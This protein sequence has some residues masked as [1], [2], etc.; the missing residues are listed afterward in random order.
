MVY[1]WPFTFLMQSCSRNLINVLH[2]MKWLPGGLSEIAVFCSLHNLALVFLNLSTDCLLPFWNRRL[3]RWS[4]RLRNEL[5]WSQKFSSSFFLS[6]SREIW[7]KHGPFAVG[8]SLIFKL[9]NIF[10]YVKLVENRLVSRSNLQSYVKLHSRGIYIYSGDSGDRKP[11][12]WYSSE[13]FA[14]FYLGLV[15]LEVYLKTFIRQNN[16]YK[17][18]FFPNVIILKNSSQLIQLDS[19]GSDWNDLPDTGWPNPCLFTVNVWTL[20]LP[21]CLKVGRTNNSW[22]F[23]FKLSV[24]VST[25]NVTRISS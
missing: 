19:L 24:S 12:G 20:T 8:S 7:E 10:P 9:R 11:F 3:F 16:V 25:T 1:A 5:A 13:F 18:L 2:V 23:I 17:Y 21:F 15:A 22:H 4:R 6:I 14:S